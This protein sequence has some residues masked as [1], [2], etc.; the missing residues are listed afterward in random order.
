[1]LEF[2]SSDRVVQVGLG[3]VYEHLRTLLPEPEPEEGGEEA[4]A[5]GPMRQERAGQDGAAAALE[6]A[7]SLNP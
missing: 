6:G 4:E 1:M 5:A 3:D 2:N 7:P